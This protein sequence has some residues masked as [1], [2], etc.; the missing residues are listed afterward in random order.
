VAGGGLGHR[1]GSCDSGRR[2]KCEE[3]EEGL[4]PF[5]SGQQT[6]LLLSDYKESATLAVTSAVLGKPGTGNKQLD[7]N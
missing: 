2:E 5:T 4:K 6:S 7:A 3:R 1:R